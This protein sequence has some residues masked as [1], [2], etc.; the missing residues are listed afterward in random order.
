MFSKIHQ[1]T[2]VS[3][4]GNFIADS[5]SL[6]IIQHFY[7]LMTQFV[8]HICTE[9]C[10]SLLGFLIAFLNNSY[11]PLYFC[12]VSSRVFFSHCNFIYLGLLFISEQ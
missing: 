12:G 3:L 9:Y 11:D 5:V 4:L 6:V 8:G 7:V 10:L 1:E 2:C